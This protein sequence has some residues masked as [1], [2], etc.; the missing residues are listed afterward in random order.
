MQ[1]NKFSK[2]F[3]D[4]PLYLCA[5]TASTALLGRHRRALVTVA[6]CVVSPP[7]APVLPL[8]APKQGAAR[9]EVGAWR[10]FDSKATCFK[11]KVPNCGV[12]LSADSSSKR[13]TDQTC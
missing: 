6:G 10:G 9:W 1:I 4:F 5:N 12:E 2:Y 3:A 7:P 13:V 8:G 11:E